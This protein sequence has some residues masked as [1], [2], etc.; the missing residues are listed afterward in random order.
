MGTMEC[1]WEGVILKKSHMKAIQF[2]NRTHFSTVLGK[3][4]S[5]GS[6]IPKV[7]HRGQ[8]IEI[9]SQGSAESGLCDWKTF[10]SRTTNGGLRWCVFV[11]SASSP[12]VGLILGPYPS[13]CIC[14]VAT[15][16][17]LLSVPAAFQCHI[18]IQVVECTG[19]VM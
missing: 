9:S 2:S 6:L 13:V 4:K 17:P 5:E 12:C 16:T 18:T 15:A 10:I 3:C 1:I 7:L 11:D 8:S 19:S 14:T